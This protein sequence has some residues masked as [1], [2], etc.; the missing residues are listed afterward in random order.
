[1]GCVV[2]LRGQKA[3]EIAFSLER[4]LFDRGHMATVI[5]PDDAT[6]RKLGELPQEVDQLVHRMATAGLIVIASEALDDAARKLATAHLGEH[7]S[8]LVELGETVVV[9]GNQISA[10][11]LDP[12]KLAGKIADTLR[13]RELLLEN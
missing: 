4:T 12:E 6:S 3:S 10:E 11:S 7:R 1:V 13:V 8:I 2:W 9:D 5:D